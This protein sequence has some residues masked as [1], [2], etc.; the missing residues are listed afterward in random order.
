MNVS[1]LQTYRHSFQRWW[2][3]SCVCW[4]IWRTARL[5]LRS[6]SCC[7]SRV[8]EHL[9]RAAPS[10]P[11]PEPNPSALNGSLRRLGPAAALRCISLKM[12]SH[13]LIKYEGREIVYESNVFIFLVN[14][15]AVFIWILTAAVVN[16]HRW[17]GSWSI[18]CHVVHFDIQGLISVCGQI[19]KI[20]C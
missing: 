4:S 20:E 17:S 12:T 9:Q 14:S 15:V 6:S 16:V 3:H 19:K 10:L 18:R 1:S 7:W 13:L 2:L 5:L 8:W 11:E